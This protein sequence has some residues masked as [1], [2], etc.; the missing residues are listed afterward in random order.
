MDTALCWFTPG[1]AFPDMAL[2]AHESLDHCT[3]YKER[4]EYLWD[5]PSSLSPLNLTTTLSSSLPN[6]K[7]CAAVAKSET[8]TSDVVTARI[9]L[10]KLF[11]ANSPTVNLA[12]STPQTAGRLLVIKP[13]GNI[14]DIPSNIPPTSMVL[15]FLL[16]GYAVPAAREFFKLPPLWEDY[17]FCS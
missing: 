15:P 13:V 4:E 6:T 10:R 12:H 8:S 16:A 1:S 11:H 17:L 7:Q 3:S 5:I 2:T 9:S 14:A